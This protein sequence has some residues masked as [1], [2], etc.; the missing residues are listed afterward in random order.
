MI[1]TEKKAILECFEGDRIKR[2]LN[3][4]Q[5]EKVISDENLMR[6]IK[7]GEKKLQNILNNLH[8]EFALSCGKSQLSEMKKFLDLKSS[9][10]LHKTQFKELIHKDLELIAKVDS[11]LRTKLLQIKDKI[12]DK[13]VKEKEKNLNTE[14]FNSIQTKIEAGLVEI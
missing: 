6:D 2:F 7:K 14:L 1:D 9:N 12:K 3:E 10:A 5:Y 4:I 8:Q 11:R 13:Q